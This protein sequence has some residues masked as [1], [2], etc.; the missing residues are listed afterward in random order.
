GFTGGEFFMN[1]DIIAML[2]AALGRGW[3]TLVLTNAMKPMRRPA[4]E[5]GL[6]ALRARYGDR[7]TLRVS[8][9]HHDRLLHD[10]ERG[11]GAWDAAVDGLGWLAGHGF[12]V[13]VAGRAAA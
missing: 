12:S 6:L 8:L 2:E 11:E 3:D 10:A 9:D 5:A 7:L 4:I 1:R 13:A